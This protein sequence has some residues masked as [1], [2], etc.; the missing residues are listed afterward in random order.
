MNTKET[1]WQVEMCWHPHLF[2]LSKKEAAAFIASVLYHL[3]GISKFVCDTGFTLYKVKIFIN[4]SSKSNE[5]GD[6]FYV[7]VFVCA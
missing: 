3:T 2:S 1:D 7:G 5:A 4:L 6:H